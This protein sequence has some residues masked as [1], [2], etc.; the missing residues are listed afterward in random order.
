MDGAYIKIIDEY[1]LIETHWIAWYVNAENIIYFDS[2][3]V[4]YISNEIRKFLANEYIIA[5]IHR[6][7]SIQF[8][9][10]ILL[11]WIY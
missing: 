2:F 9:M 4:E 5:N 3:R 11:Y 7:Q 10:W 6:I 1:E 8:M